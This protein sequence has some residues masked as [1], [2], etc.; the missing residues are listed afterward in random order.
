MKK[1]DVFDVGCTVFVG[2]HVE[3]VVTS[4]LIR[5]NSHVLYECSWW[6][7]NQHYSG[8]FEEFEVSSSVKEKMVVGFTNVKHK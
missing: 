7:K 6:D 8:Y 2:D 3:A 4:I 5:A 1:I